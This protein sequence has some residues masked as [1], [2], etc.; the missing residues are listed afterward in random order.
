MSNFTFQP[1][2][3]QLEQIHFWVNLG[4][5][6]FL[7]QRFSLA[8]W[9]ADFLV[10]NHQTWQHQ[11]FLF[12]WPPTVNK[13]WLHGAG[14]CCIFQTCDLS[15]A[16]LTHI[17]LWPFSIA[18]KIISTIALIQLYYFFWKKPVNSVHPPKSLNSLSY[19]FVKWEQFT[20]KV[21]E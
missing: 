19:H 3:F 15:T 10:K 13:W 12:D 17:V 6:S 8:V 18:N 9:E 14:S 1:L 5:N 4:P 7:A 21:N 16:F 20:W 2:C 11:N